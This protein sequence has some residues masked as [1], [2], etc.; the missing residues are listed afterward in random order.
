VKLKKK[1]GDERM[2]KLAAGDVA[3]KTRSGNDDNRAAADGLR[4]TAVFES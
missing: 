1:N 4:R 3:R 2:S